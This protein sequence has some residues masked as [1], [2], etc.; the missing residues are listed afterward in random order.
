MVGAGGLA[1]ALEVYTQLS[2][3]F[4]LADVDVQSGPSHVAITEKAS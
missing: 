4:S 3:N 2:P 1:K